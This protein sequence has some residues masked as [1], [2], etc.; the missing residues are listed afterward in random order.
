[1]RLGDLAAAE[2]QTPTGPF[3][4]LLRYDAEHGTELAATLRAYLDSFGDVNAAAAAVHVHSNTFR[5]R[6][7]RLTEISGLDLADPE[8]RLAAMLM[9]R[10][11]GQR[12]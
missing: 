2:E 6:L 11:F 7:R 5:Y 12:H 3:Q 9:M 10:I 8:A 4:R 1:L